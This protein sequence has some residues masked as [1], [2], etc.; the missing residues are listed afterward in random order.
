MP[1][2]PRR[3]LPVPG[4]DNIRDLGGYRTR[5]GHLTK[6]RRMLRGDGLHKIA[7][8]GDSVLRDAGLRS[9]IDLRSG[10]ELVEEPN[11]FATATGIDFNPLPLFNDLAPTMQGIKTRNP[12]DLLLDFYLS[13]L[14]DSTGPI[15][16]ILGTIAEAPEGAVLFHCTAG[17]DRTGLIAALLLGTAGVDRDT[18]IDDYTMTGQRIGPL[19]AE[20]LARTRANGGDVETHARFLRSDPA[21]MA[22]TLDHIDREHGSIPGYLQDIGVSKGQISV[23]RDRLLGD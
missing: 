13:A 3:V 4:A 16:D 17:K 14:R 5:D 2:D 15:R 10:A 11:P 18:I 12:D 8:G 6:W 20:L 22:A 7:P 1:N 23:L 9:V 19:I 21:T